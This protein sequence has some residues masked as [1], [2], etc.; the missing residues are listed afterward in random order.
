MSRGS[1]EWRKGRTLLAMSA[2]GW[3]AGGVDP[4]DDHGSLRE[5]DD[6]ARVQVPAQTASP[7]GSPASAAATSSRSRRAP[8]ISCSICRSRMRR[9]RRGSRAGSG[10]EAIRA[11]TEA[12]NSAKRSA[13]RA[14]GRERITSRSTGPSTNSKTIPRRPCTSTSPSTTGTLTPRLAHR[15]RDRRLLVRQVG[16]ELGA[17]HFQDAVGAPREDVGRSTNTDEGS[18]FAAS[19]QRNTIRPRYSIDDPEATTAGYLRQ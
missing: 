6:V 14:Q 2:S 13:P 3:P 17:D 11:C 12:C 10:D 18:G 1:T 8:V 15:P 19:H 9:A 4:V 16:W 5:H 7:S